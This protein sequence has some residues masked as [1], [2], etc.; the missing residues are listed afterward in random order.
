MKLC[1]FL[2]MIGLVAMSMITLAS[3]HA[4]DTSAPDLVL[5]ANAFGAQG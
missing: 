4:Q 5:N 2:I 3:T 1:N